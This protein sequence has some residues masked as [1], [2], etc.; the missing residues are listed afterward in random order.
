[1]KKRDLTFTKKGI[2]LR[3]RFSKKMLL[4][5]ALILGVSS[6]LFFSTSVTLIQAI[7]GLV[8]VF[9]LSLILLFIIT[10]LVF[11]ILDKTRKKK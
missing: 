2:T 11:F 4:F 6:L 5:S 7:S 10:F 3:E 9:S 8:M 1:M